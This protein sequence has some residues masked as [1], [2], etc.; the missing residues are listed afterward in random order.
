MGRSIVQHVLLNDEGQPVANQ[1]VQILKPD[2]TAF[3]G[4][5]YDQYSG[6]GVIL[7][8]ALQSD[9]SG[10]VQYWTDK[11]TTRRVLV[12]PTG[13]ANE[14]LSQF[15]HDPEDVIVQGLAVPAVLDGYTGSADYA[16]RVRSQNATTGKAFAVENQAGDKVLTVERASSNQ[17]DAVRINLLNGTVPTDNL[18]EVR[19][20]LGSTFDLVELESQTTAAGIIVATLN[21]LAKQTVAGVSNSIGVRSTVER[22]GSATADG[23]AIGFEAK[24]KATVASPTS[25]RFF[26]G[27]MATA[28]AITSGVR[29]GAAFVADGTRGW[30]YGF[31]Y[32]DTDNTTHLA[33]I[34]SAGQFRSASGSSAGYSFVGDADT[35]VFRSAANVLDLRAGGT[36]YLQANHGVT[37]LL[38]RTFK[39]QADDTYVLGDSDERWARLV[40]GRGL[41]GAPS[42]AIGDDGSGLYSSGTNNVLITTVGVARTQW[43][44]LGNMVHGAAIATN[45]TNGFIYIPT[46]AGTPTGTPTTYGGRLPL[47][48]DSTNHIMYFYSGSWRAL[49]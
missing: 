49:N 41:V 19:K 3:G 30:D 40:V 31:I 18:F 34:D 5:F 36:S 47:V 15:V 13:F 48:I 35:L 12:R 7:S 43:D 44:Q 22:S 45:A 37:S 17:N 9:A 24:L 1:G 4:S 16:L 33:L 10:L 27:F 23:V 20:A 38:A 6:S 21:V 11:E 2:G 29:T 28:D 32:F 25:P 14:Q 42:I 26:A 39:P 46:C 8:S